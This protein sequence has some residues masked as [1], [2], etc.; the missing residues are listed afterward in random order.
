MNIGTDKFFAE[1][2]GKREGLSHNAWIVWEEYKAN[3]VVTEILENVAKGHGGKVDYSLPFVILKRSMTCLETYTNM[4]SKTF[5]ILDTGDL[6]RQKYVIESLLE[7]VESF[8]Y[9]PTL[10]PWLTYQIN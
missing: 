10:T 7:S 4:L 8:F 9:A 1:P 6:H 3:K 2:K 5:K